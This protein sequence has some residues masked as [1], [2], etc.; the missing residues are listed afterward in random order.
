MFGWGG[1]NRAHSNGALL[2]AEYIA[3]VEQVSRCP[4]S[5]LPA[6]DTPGDQDYVYLGYLVKGDE[7][8]EA[9]AEAY[10]ERVL[11]GGEGLFEEDLSF[12]KQP[13]YRLRQGIE[14]IF[15][16]NGSSPESDAWSQAQLP[17]LIEW[18]DRHETTSDRQGGNV[19][20]MDGHVEFMVYPGKW[21]MTE[22]TMGIL[23]ELAG[24]DPVELTHTGGMSVEELRKVASASNAV[25]A[26][27][28]AP[29]GRRG[30]GMRLGRSVAA[31]PAAAPT[32]DMGNLGPDAPCGTR[33]KYLGLAL[34]VFANESPGG[35]W[36]PMSRD[37]AN[38]MFL[39]G[40]E[41]DTVDGQNVL[42][43]GFSPTIPTTVVCRDSGRAISAPDD[44]DFVYLGYV[45][46][47]EGDLRRFAEA[48]EAW[49]AAGADKN[50][51][52][53]DDKP[54]SPDKG[55]IRIREGVERFL[56]TDIN[57]PAAS[58][59]AQ[60]NIPVVIEWPDHHVDSGTMGG[61]VLFMDGHVEFMA[62]PGDFPMTEEAMEILCKLA[63]RD[64][65]VVEGR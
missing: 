4:L 54:A 41:S 51:W 59:M 2:S 26:T 50:A 5:P 22:E 57:N 7:S 23:A 60:S 33:L 40:G 65:I 9:F 52:F 16:P 47:D 63:G 45:M 19:L 43:T 62:Y 15:F 6:S 8:V 1:D 39:W 56:I 17:V 18:P 34:K 30:G 61:N 25:E 35:V 31:T 46:R 44:T 3:G 28:P 36:P 24:R 29:T 20:F 13:V 32:F 14:R 58:A 53:T 12:S 11:L 49:A 21:P 27:P 48:Y 64:A 38:M 37:L 55:I 42:S 10:R